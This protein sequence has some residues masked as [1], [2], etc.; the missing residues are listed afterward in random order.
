MAKM[1][2]TGGFKDFVILPEEYM[3]MLE[4]F[5][6]LPDTIEPE[7]TEKVTYRVG[8]F[9]PYA[10]IQ[11]YTSCALPQPGTF[12]RMNAYKCGDATSHPHWISW[13]PVRELNFHL[14]ED[15]GVLEFC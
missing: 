1:K 8:F 15:F 5:H 4:K 7:I 10:L 3:L 9:V 13:N 11:K 2:K 12:W 6:T 14:P